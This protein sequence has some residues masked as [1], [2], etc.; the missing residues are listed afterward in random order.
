MSLAAAGLLA[1]ALMSASAATG[2]RAGQ[3]VDVPWRAGNAS[4]FQAGAAEERGARAAHGLLP[5]TIHRPAGPGPFPFVVLLHGGGGLHREAMWTTWVEPWVEL[6]RTHGIGTAVV[7]SFASRGVDQVCTGNVAAWAARHADDA[8]SVRAWLGGQSYADAARVAVMGMSNG[9]R[10]VPAAL[11]APLKHREP[12]VAGVA[13][14][15]GCQSDVAS[16]FYAPLLVLI[17]NADTVTLA[18]FCEEMKRAQPES[19]PELKL[20][21]YPRAPHTFDIRLPD[22]TVLGMRLGYDAQAT[23]DAYRQVIDFLAAHRLARCPIGDLSRPRL[24]DSA[25]NRVIVFTNLRPH[26]RS[27]RPSSCIDVTGPDSRSPPSPVCSPRSP[28]PPPKAAT[29]AVAA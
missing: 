18:R 12:F 10:T 13:L 27:G 6:F 3:V 9:G 1:T 24:I 16:V 11:R 8:Y 26:H 25:R 23:A 20:V 28:P 5:V 15:P 4:A 22:R 19:A 21:A 17:G 7:D 14:D 2:A 29:G